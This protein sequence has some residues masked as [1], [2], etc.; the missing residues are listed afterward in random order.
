M[1]PVLLAAALA[2]PVDGG[3]EARL[4]GPVPVA[5]VATTAPYQPVPL[6]PMWPLLGLGGAG[7][8]LFGARKSLI[9]ALGGGSKC[10]DALVVVSKKNLGHGGLAVVDVT[11]PSGEIRRLLVGTGSSGPRLLADLSSDF[12]ALG[13]GEEEA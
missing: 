8:L 4:L 3:L 10:S 1:I 2:A 13:F 6:P 12:E 9:A 7:L 11:E 5:S